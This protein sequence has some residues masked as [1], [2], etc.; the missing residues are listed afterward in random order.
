[1]MAKPMKILE[2]QYPMI[3]I[4]ITKNIQCFNNQSE[5][6]FNAIHCFSLY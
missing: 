6:I 5:G 4:L 1:M 3:Q 2:L